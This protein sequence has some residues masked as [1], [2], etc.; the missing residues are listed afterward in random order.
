MWCSSRGHLGQDDYG[1]HLTRGRY[2][3]LCSS[4]VCDTLDAS[5]RF[6]WRAGEDKGGMDEGDLSGLYVEDTESGV[7]EPA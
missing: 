2:G 6:N 3:H 5:G 4:Q 7:V 1:A